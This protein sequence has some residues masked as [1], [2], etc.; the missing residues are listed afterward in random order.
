MKYEESMRQ[1]EQIVEQ[2]ENNEIDIEALA[3]NIKT[4]NKLLAN[5]EKQLTDAKTEVEQLLKED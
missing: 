5:C 3:K 2:I 4:A 1:V